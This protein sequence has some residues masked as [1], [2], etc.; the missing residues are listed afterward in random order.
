MFDALARLAQDRGKLVAALAIVFFLA[1][2]AFG[3]GVADKLDPYGAD[4]PDTETVKAAERLERAGHREV[5][6]VVL[7]QDAPAADPK[8]SQRAGRIAA[9]LTRDPDVEEVSGFGAN[10]RQLDFVALDAQSV[11]MTVTLKPTDDKAQQE[12]G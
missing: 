11:Y 5:G 10:S 2:G 7:L 1:A 6:V 3:S 9:Q 12:A 8:T 4:D